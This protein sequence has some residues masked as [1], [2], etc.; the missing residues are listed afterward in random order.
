M[1]LLLDDDDVRHD[2]FAEVFGSSC[3]H[4][5]SFS[6]F[7][8][9]VNTN[10]YSHIFLDHD[11]SDM[12]PPEFRMTGDVITGQDAAAFLVFL[13]KEKQPKTVT[14]HS[15]NDDGAGHMINMLR[16]A[17]ISATRYKYRPDMD[18]Y[19]FKEE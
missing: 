14:V 5:Y 16:S 17:G 13:E 10:R 3:D 15:T 1:I 4:A 7:K 2:L 18:L 9:K 6:E 19:Q 11:L 12:R 8:V